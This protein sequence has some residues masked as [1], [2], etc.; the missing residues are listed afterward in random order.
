MPN[1]KPATNTARAFIE[2]IKIAERKSI[3]DFG[4]HVGADNQTKY[5]KL[6]H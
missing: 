1:T 3:V 4:F 5:K 6:A 2:K